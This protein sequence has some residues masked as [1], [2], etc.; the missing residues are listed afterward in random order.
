NHPSGDPTPSPE[1]LVVTRHL[2][3]AGRLLGVEVL[4]HLVVCPERF[5]SLREAGTL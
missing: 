3:E 1:D 5:R 2:Q 4:D